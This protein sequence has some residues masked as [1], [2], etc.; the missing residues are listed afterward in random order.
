MQHTPGYTLIRRILYPYSGEESLSLKQGLRVVLA[1]MLFFPLCMCL[2]TLA[3]AVLGSFTLQRMVM[4]LI[5]VFVSGVLIFGMLGL[6]I[7][8]MGNKAARFRQTW[9]TRKD[10][11]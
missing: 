2:L 3:I 11:Q 9:N 8:S 10:Q 4:L 6:I 1:W 5:F 7:V